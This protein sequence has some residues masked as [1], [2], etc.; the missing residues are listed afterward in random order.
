MVIAWGKMRRFSLSKL[1]NKTGDKSTKEA[2][3]TVKIAIS[4]EESVEKAVS[5]NGV[6][7]VHSKVSNSDVSSFS[8]ELPTKKLILKRFRTSVMHEIQVPLQDRNNNIR[9]QV[10][11][12]GAQSKET[13]SVTQNW[14]KSSNRSMRTNKENT[15]MFTVSVKNE[16]LHI[17][18]DTA[19]T[20]PMATQLQRDYLAPFDFEKYKIF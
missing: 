13:V 9:S 14:S 4:T 1:V 12:V 3:Q 19:I 18:V 16:E 8:V 11:F 15:Q 6:E 5:E 17:N 7:N 10:H 20:A 2:K